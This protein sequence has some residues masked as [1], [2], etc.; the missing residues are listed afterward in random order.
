MPFKRLHIVILG[1]GYGGTTLVHALRNVPNVYVTLIDKR[2]HHMVQ[3]EI[4]RYLGG[5]AEEDDILF[6]LASFCEKNGA[7]FLCEQAIFIDNEKKVVKCEN[8]TTLSYD[9]LVVATGS[10]SLFP[11]QIQ[12][13]DA[14]AKDVKTLEDLQG[15]KK[16]FENLIS[17]KP[18]N[19]CIAIVGGGLT[20]VEIALEYGARLKRLGFLKDECRVALVEQQPSLLPGANQNLIDEASN[21]CKSLDIECY[22]GA[23]VTKIADNHLYLSD[24]RTIP[25]HTLLL[26][27]GV[28]SKPLKFKQDIS[29]SPR[30]QIIVNK[31]LHVEEDKTLFAIGD[32]A[33]FE[34][35]DGKMILPTAQN[36]KQQAKS[37]AKNIK[38]ILEDKP[39]NKYKFQN[40]GVLVD[41]ADKNA[42]G[43]AFGIG[44]KGRRA[45]SLKRTVN[46]MHTKIF[47]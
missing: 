25:F 44:V 7:K 15:F 23:F 28:T 22:H 1:G 8:E 40:R 46:S 14:Y 4:H 26:T 13:I 33:Y 43:N 36:A 19:E 35:K 34:D 11:K 29:T 3:T 41:L 6:D 17:S 10:V 18:K 27:I 12:N 24:E 38:R 47:K 31:S 30:G 45:Y 20:G 42:V 39:L 16:A 5:E 21:A 9:I 32:V 2:T 37:V